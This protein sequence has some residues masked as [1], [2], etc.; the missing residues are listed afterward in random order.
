METYY[1]V[2]YEQGGKKFAWRRDTVMR[3]YYLYWSYK[4]ENDGS[5][6]PIYENLRLEEVSPSGV[7]VLRG[8]SGHQ[9]RPEEKK[10]EVKPEPTPV[11]MDLFEYLTGMSRQE[12]NECLDNWNRLT[13][14]NVEHI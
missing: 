14:E 9:V 6:I 13:G 7:V 3:G 2:T 11:P 12:Y 4:E 5:P 8:K 10:P 1:Q